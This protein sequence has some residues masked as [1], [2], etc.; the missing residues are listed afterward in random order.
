MFRF[1]TFTDR[2][3]GISTRG[4][5]GTGV[6]RTVQDAYADNR[7]PTAGR[8]P[9]GGTLTVSTHQRL[10]RLFGLGLDTT[11]RECRHCGTNVEPDDPQCPTCGS[12]GIV[13][14]DV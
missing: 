2:G 9:P 3:D 10:G 5:V 12:D 14:Y 13:E 6:A 1:F 11:V 8:H 4:T 7:S